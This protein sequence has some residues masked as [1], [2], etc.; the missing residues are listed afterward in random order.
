[1]IPGAF[2]VV[3]YQ[4]HWD[5]CPLL[6]GWPPPSPQ[7]SET[8]FSQASGRLLLLLNF[9]G[10]HHEQPCWSSAS[11]TTS[12]CREDLSRW[13]SLTMSQ[14]KCGAPPAWV[15]S[16]GHNRKKKSKPK[17]S[18]CP[19]KCKHQERQTVMPEPTFK[20]ILATE[21]ISQTWRLIFK[22]T[23]HPPVSQT[24][25]ILTFHAE[26]VFLKPGPSMGN[27]V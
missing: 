11:L 7:V 23:L 4:W 16:H 14:M 13:R 12:H 19:P 2:E 26:V 8:L 1:M 22:G 27:S 21:F 15:L 17:Q 3:S 24:A 9:M 25:D 6:R 20:A 10:S 5:L 18:C